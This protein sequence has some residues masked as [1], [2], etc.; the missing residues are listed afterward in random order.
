[1]VTTA[2]AMRVAVSFAF[3]CGNEEGDLD[4]RAR[5][6]SRSTTLRYPAISLVTAW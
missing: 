6:R 1:M 3:A 5:C 4:F 2:G